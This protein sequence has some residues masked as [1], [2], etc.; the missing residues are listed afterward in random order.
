[1]VLV[2]VISINKK[3]K[4]PLYLQIKESITEAINDGRLRD[5]D[6]L[7]YEENI[8]S[9]YRV[10]RQVVRQ[11]YQELEEEG[12]IKRV[13]RKG[14]F[15]SLKPHIVATR[16]EMFS[17]KNMVQ[18][19]GFNYKRK[20]ILVESIFVNNDLFPEVMKENFQHVLH[21][22]MVINV[23]DYPFFFIHVFVPGHFK[24]EFDVLENNEYI[25]ND[26]FKKFGV[27]VRESIF[28]IKPKF[29]TNIDK[30]TLNLQEEKIL[31]E[32]VIH[33]IDKTETCVAVEKIL[34]NG[35]L[36]YQEAIQQYEK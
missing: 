16:Q 15:V 11:A 18:S 27:D 22:S 33:Y 13:K 30:I 31:T 24:L 34:V 23:N 4:T 21:V 26:W 19:R 35:K 8:S 6:Q 32:H 3:K 14:T 7:P 20:V 5:N 36:F 1:M 25:M 10:S 9:F 17:I 12:L 28:S 29:A 2:N